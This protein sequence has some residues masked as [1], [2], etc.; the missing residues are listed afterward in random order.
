[1]RRVLRDLAERFDHVV[2]DT[3]PLLPVADAAAL[4][5]AVDAYLLVVRAHRTTWRELA[6]AV[7]ILGYTGATSAGTV[8]NRATRGG[9]ARSYHRGVPAQATLPSPRRD[10]PV[11]Q[12]LTVPCAPTTH[13]TVPIPTVYTTESATL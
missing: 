4:A 8:L 11:A 7:R 12:L 2:V 9:T 6:R 3:G 13:T 5:P 10:G 1:M